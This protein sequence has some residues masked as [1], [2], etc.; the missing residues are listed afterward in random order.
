[1]KSSHLAGLSLEAVTISSP[2]CRF[3]SFVFNSTEQL[4]FFLFR[5]KDRE[6]TF[7]PRKNEHKVFHKAAALS[8]RSIKSVTNDPFFFTCITSPAS[9]IFSGT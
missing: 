6:K 2:V 4:V 9:S 7:K 3:L 5:S 8:I 1:M